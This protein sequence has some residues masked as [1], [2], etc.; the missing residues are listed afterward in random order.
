APAVVAVDEEQVVESADAE[1]AVHD[2]PRSPLLHKAAGACP[3]LTYHLTAV[4]RHIGSN[5][6][7]GHYVTLAAHDANL[8]TTLSS[9]MQHALT[10]SWLCDDAR[11]T[12][13]PDAVLSDP[14]FQGDAYIVYYSLPEASD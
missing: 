13:A 10:R 1:D 8:D 5:A 14:R 3:P 11:S 9:H 7:G 2:A 12:P 6:G 4:V